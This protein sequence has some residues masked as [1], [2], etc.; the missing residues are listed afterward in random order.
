MARITYGSIVTEINGSLGGTTFQRNGY[1]Y[2]AKNKAGMVRPF[3]E[4]QKYVQSVMALAVKAWKTEPQT[5]RD[6]WN[7]WASVNPRYA[8][9]D[10][11]RQL[12]GQACFVKWHFYRFLSSYYIDVSPQLV[13]PAQPEI[14]LTLKTNGT[15]FNIDITCPSTAEAW[16][17]Y[18]FLSRPLPASQTFLG[19]KARFVL[20]TTDLTQTR[21]IATEY[22]SRF[23]SLPAVG[24][25]IGLQYVRAMEEGG[26]VNT[27]V[28]Q[29]ITVSAIS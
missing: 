26:Q 21:D 11:T 17:L 24:D 3:T 10:L 5:T 20:F 9:H 16:N 22:I 28:Q 29:F 13:I 18:F 25:I 8:K 1:G 4:Y 23:G 27:R 15:L 19:T 14:T 6:S 2:T 7:T 12:S